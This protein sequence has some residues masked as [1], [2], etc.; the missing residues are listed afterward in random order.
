MADSTE[1]AATISVGGLLKRLTALGMGREIVPNTPMI[2]SLEGYEMPIGAVE[3]DHHGR[4]VLRVVG[5]LE[6][7]A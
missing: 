3:Q 7:L 6:L 4:I 2:V 5:G 1:V